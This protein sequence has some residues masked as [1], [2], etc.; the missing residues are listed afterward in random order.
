[1]RIEIFSK[2]L[3]GYKCFFSFWQFFWTGLAEAR[4]I[5]AVDAIPVALVYF[6]QAI[7]EQPPEKYPK[8]FP[9]KMKK[10]EKTKALKS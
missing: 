8:K 5:T 9:E 2:S 3:A 6:D 10:G 7:R 1:M 4:E